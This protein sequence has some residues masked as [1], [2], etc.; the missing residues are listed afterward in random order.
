MSLIT[1]LLARTEGKEARIAYALSGTVVLVCWVVILNAGDVIRSGDEPDFLTTSQNLATTGVFA[2]QT[3]TPDAYR[4]PGLVFFLTPFTALGAGIVEARLANAALVGLSL[5][6]LFQ[7]VRRHS[8]ALAGL[9]SVIMVAAWPVVI[10]TA[11]TLYPQT[12]AAFLL[13]LTLW[14]LDGLRDD[15]TARASVLGG[16]AY[17]ALILT[18]PVVLLLTPVF[19]VW[20]AAMSKRWVVAVAVFGLLSASVVGSWTLRNWI[21]FDSF[22]PVATSSG[23]NLLAGNTANARWNTSVEIR[24]P[25]HVYTDITG[26]ND[27]ERNDIMTK[28]ALAEIT[29]DPSRFIQRYVGKFV[30]WFHFSN[31]LLSDRVMEAG[32]SA[33][34]VRLREIILFAA[35]TVLIV[36]PLLVRLAMVRRIPM[37]GI[38]ILFLTLWVAAGL[39]YALYFTR[40]RFRLPFD[41][42]IISMNAMFVAALI[43]RYV[44]SPAKR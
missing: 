29:A 28:A 4:A 36:G 42:L 16:L 26:K 7:L 5:V 31:R 11:S 2:L 15:A 14:C 43:E 24:F 37:K 17:G 18:I 44:K 34:P 3:G 22:I 40:V 20:I 25:E 13:I 9:V 21:T 27:V 30:H 6:L 12:L 23:Y 38:E 32:A 19:V 33:V 8:G 39:A 35:W 10:Y 41:W 1:W